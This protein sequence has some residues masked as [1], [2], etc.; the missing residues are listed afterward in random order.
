MGR[1]L[2][3]CQQITDNLSDKYGPSTI[4]VPKPEENRPLKYEP[5]EAKRVS[6][7]IIQS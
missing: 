4:K 7:L 6:E 2:T 5:L 3:R 1:L